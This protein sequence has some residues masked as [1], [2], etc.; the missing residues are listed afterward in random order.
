MNAE[1]FRALADRASTIE[2]RRD[3]RLAE[4]HDR[5]RRAG[6]RRQLVAV[7][8]SAVAVVLALTAGVGL[9]ALTDTDRTPPAEPAPRPTSTPRV[10]D[11]APS[12]RRVTYAEGRQ[13]PLGRPDASTW[14]ARSVEVAATDDGV[15]F[16]RGREELARPAATATA[17]ATPSGSPTGRTSSASARASD[18]VI[19]GYRI[20]FSTAGSTV[21]W[22]EPAP[23]DRP[24]P[25]DYRE[26]GEYVVYDTGE[27]REVARFGSAS[28]AVI[29]R[30]CY[31]DYVYWIPDDK[32]W[33]LDSRGTTASAGAT[34]GDDAARD[35]DR[36]AGRR[37][38]G[39]RTWPT[40][41]AGRARVHQTDPRRGQHSRPPCYDESITFLRDGN[42][43][44]GRRRGGVRGHRPRGRGPGE[45]V[46]LRL[47]AGLRRR[48]RDFFMM[49]QWLDD[50]RVVCPGRR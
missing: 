37:S 45:P 16:V 17:G 19:R 44:V 13:D 28:G 35:L 43:L 23:D 42:R 9:L 31:D 21:V 46:R 4:V 12:V 41:A 22:F 6:R 39:R 1:D 26:R 3:D 27:R 30:R 15:V 2:G 7:T 11:T 10:P 48:G 38:P 18:T 25:S 8:A 40:G 24:L 36:H 5:I 20:E 50:D 33:C 47:P 29:R 34:R 49:V 14:A 32:T